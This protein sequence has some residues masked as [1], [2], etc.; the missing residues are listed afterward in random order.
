MKKII[1]QFILSFFFSSLVLF[2]YATN[3]EPG[4]TD[5]GL[6]PTPGK[7]NQEATLSFNF[8]NG[9]QA[10][11][12]GAQ[13]GITVGLYKM[14]FVLD[15]NGAPIITG[16]NYFTWTIDINGQLKGT[17]NKG[18]GALQNV[19]ITIKVKYTVSST[20]AESGTV[21]GN[22]ALVNIQQGA[23]N[24]STKDDDMVSIYTYTDGVLAVNFG[25]IKSSFIGNKLLVNWES[26]KEE[27]NKEFIIEASKDGENFVEIARV[28]S[29]AKDGNSTEA[30]H[31]SYAAPWNE[32]AVKFGFPLAI[33]LMLTSVVLMFIASKKRKTVLLPLIVLS[34]SFIVYSCNKK[35]KE[36]QAKPENVFVR[37][38]QVD[39]SQN[40]SYSA[41]SKAVSQ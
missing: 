25:S 21:N 30:I 15:N 32:V 35:D 9:S 22:G 2:C 29:L 18:I 40:I 24:N 1:L 10:I 37:V 26:L 7:V 4:V 12:N 34:L 5:P 28:A 23:T 31:Y 39:K 14:A 33:V 20:Q 27:N 6:T 36:E 16:P 19:P 13:V 38:G 8:L 11:P 3:G 41:A 17:Q